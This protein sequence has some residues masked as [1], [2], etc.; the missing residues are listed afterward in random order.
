MNPYHW[1]DAFL[2]PT[3]YQTIRKAVEEAPDDKTVTLHRLPLGASIVIHKVEDPAERK[4]KAFVLSAIH[5]QP[6]AFEN[7]R[8]GI[9]VVQM[10]KTD[11]PLVLSKR[12]VSPKP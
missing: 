11:F 1:K 3:L 12:G 6:V 4:A 7:D 8:G 10:P 2:G 9:S 5:G